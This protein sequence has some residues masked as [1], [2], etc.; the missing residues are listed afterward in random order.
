M[1]LFCKEAREKYQDQKWMAKCRGIEFTLTL[2]QWV[3]WWELNLGSNWL[4]KRGPRSGQYVMAR[5][6]DKGPYA[7]GNIECVTSNKNHADMKKYRSYAV[8]NIKIPAKGVIEIFL[9]D[10][11]EEAELCKKYDTRYSYIAKIKRREVWADLTKDLGE[12]KLKGY[13]KGASH[14]RAK[15]NEE[16]VKAVYLAQGSNADIAAALSVEKNK[17]SLIRTGL[18]WRSVTLQLGPIPNKKRGPYKR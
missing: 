15:L 9:S 12:P 14:P 6:G 5:K 11:N 13:G 4:K 18:I 10:P 3:G 16:T 7:I 8:T 1:K 2:D 17:V